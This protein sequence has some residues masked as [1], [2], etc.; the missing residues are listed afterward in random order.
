MAACAFSDGTFHRGS[1]LIVAEILFAA[2]FVL[3]GNASGQQ[4]TPQLIL[5]DGQAIPFQ[6]LEIAEGKLRGEG[7]PAGLTLDDLRRI[8]LASSD[9]PEKPPIVAELRGGGRIYAKDVSIGE[10]KCQLAWAN[11]EPLTVP[12][13][14]VR[15]IRTAPALASADFEKALATPSGE[16]DRVFIK[17]DAGKVNSVLGLIKSLTGQQLTI[18][19]GAEVRNVPRERVIGIVVAQPAPNEALARCQVSFRDG[20]IVGGESVALSNEKATL[21]FPAGASVSFPWSAVSRVTIRSSRVAYLSDLKALAEEQLPIVTIS[22]PAQ[23]DKS[24]MGRPLTLGRKAF[25]K[26]LGVH[27]RSSLTFAADRKWDV[28]AAT[29]GIDAEAAGKGD[30]VFSVLADGQPLISRRMT[31]G[32]PPYEMEVPITNR[33]AITLIVEPG[34]GL[35]LADHADWCDARFMKSR[36]K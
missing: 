19:I 6:S 30:C 28:F 8:E 5:L 15:G 27:A 23:R 31:G 29:I 25:E 18:E 33:A 21:S 12:L 1:L 26:G 35:D 32:D 4:P 22:L 16:L 24:V 11:G 17:D 3:D 13:D 14:I 7:L 34:E 9:T 10:D 2:A 20:S 36:P